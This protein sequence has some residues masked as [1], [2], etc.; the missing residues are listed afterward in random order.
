MELHLR[1][2]GVMLVVLALIHAIFPRYLKWKTELVPLSL[3]NQQLLK[4]HTFFIALMVLLMGLLC[5]RASKRSPRGPYN[6]SAFGL[7]G[8]TIIAII[9]C[10]AKSVKLGSGLVYPASILGAGWVVAVQAALQDLLPAQLRATATSI[11]AFALTFAGL[12]LGVMVVGGANDYLNAAYGSDAVR[13]SMA[14]TLLAAIPAA[15]FIW[16]AGVTAE[17]DRAILAKGQGQ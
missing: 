2:V 16:R 4:V 10:F 5:D 13:Y 9:I 6:L 11:W 8:F 3:M 12:V 17:A 7:L 15:W 1:I 14:M